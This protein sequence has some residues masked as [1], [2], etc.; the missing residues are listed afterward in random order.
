[1]ITGLAIGLVLGALCAV[2]ALLLWGRRQLATDQRQ[3]L[4]SAL[5]NIDAL[6][7]FHPVDLH[8]FKK[9]GNA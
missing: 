7:G 1:M 3:A 9:A 4:A 8:W 5:P 2:G 6:R